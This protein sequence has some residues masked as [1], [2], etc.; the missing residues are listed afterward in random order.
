MAAEELRVNYCKGRICAQNLE[1]RGVTEVEFGSGGSGEELLKDNVSEKHTTYSLAGGCKVR[2]HR[3]VWKSLA[4]S[5]GRVG[6]SCWRVGKQVPPLAVAVAPDFGRNDKGLMGCGEGKSLWIEAGARFVQ[7][8]KIP[9]SCKGREGHPALP[10]R[11]KCVGQDAQP[12]VTSDLAPI[13]N[14]SHHCPAK[15]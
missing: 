6:V 13:R 15:G 10:A 4:R 5:E 8:V 12:S 11:Q 14:T 2:G 7:M 9:T 1:K 3:G